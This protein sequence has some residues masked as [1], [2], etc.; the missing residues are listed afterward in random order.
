MDDAAVIL[1]C[2]GGVADLTVTV[3]VAVKDLPLARE[4][5]GDLTATS[6]LLGDFGRGALMTSFGELFLC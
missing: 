2:C 5:V 6:C 4:D 1:L 3:G